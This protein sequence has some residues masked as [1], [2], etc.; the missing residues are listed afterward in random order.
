[1][2]DPELGERMCACVILRPGTTLTLPE[3]AEYL[4][5]QEIARHKLPERLAV[6]DRFPLSPVGKVSKKDLV[7]TLAGNGAPGGAAPLASME[8]R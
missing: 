8:D 2:P 1:V 4:A 3:L 5:G 6:L 7:A